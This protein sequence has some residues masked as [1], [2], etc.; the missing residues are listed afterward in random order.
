[1]ISALA[2]RSRALGDPSAASLAQLGLAAGLRLL[3]LPPLVVASVRLLDPGNP[4]VAR[5][6]GVET[7][8][9]VL[10]QLAVSIAAVRRGP[11]ESVGRLLVPASLAGAVVAVGDIV[12]AWFAFGT[13]TMS[14]VV[15]V[16]AYDLVFGLL[17][18]VPVVVVYRA[19]SRCRAALARSEI[20]ASPR[21]PDPGVR[22]RP[23]RER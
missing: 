19:T 15:S 5:I 13:L 4:V 14:G 20:D 23:G 21:G 2:H 10:A 1:M 22:A 8:V 9:I 16:L 18:A 11:A 12:A 3:V 6:L 17:L 7:V